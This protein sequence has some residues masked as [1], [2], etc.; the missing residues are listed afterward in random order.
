MF[1]FCFCFTLLQLIGHR[2]ICL[3]FEILIASREKICCGIIF[4]GPD[5]EVLIYP[6]LL[7]PCSCRQK[8][9][10]IHINGSG[11]S[12]TASVTSSSQIEDDANSNG[13][14][15]NNYSL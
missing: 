13:S 10:K 14:N 7:K 2:R 6:K 1:L 8:M 12:D 3:C 4:K 9:Y 11:S 5:N 15:S